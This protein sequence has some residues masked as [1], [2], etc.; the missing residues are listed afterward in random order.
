MLRVNPH[1][2]MMSRLVGGDQGVTGGSV[3]DLPSYSSTL[4]SRVE[5]MDVSLTLPASHTL[6]GSMDPPQGVIEISGH[7]QNTHA[8]ATQVSPSDLTYVHVNG[9]KVAL[10]MLLYENYNFIL[11]KI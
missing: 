4:D 7:S 1:P 2:D 10:K 8:K 3:K 5:P 6:H 9:E 11:K